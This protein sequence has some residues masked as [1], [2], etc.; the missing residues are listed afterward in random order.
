M[1]IASLTPAPMPSEYYRRQAA[2]LRD[3]AL[4]ATTHT[5]REH[6]AEVALQY[7]QLAE[8]ADAG[9]RTQET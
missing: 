8:R 1:V 9:Y 2:R 5:I 3:L 4:D 6:L 7:E